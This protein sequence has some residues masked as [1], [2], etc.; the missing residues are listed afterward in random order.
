MDAT[1]ID[2]V[3]IISRA[4]AV[5][6][7]IWAKELNLTTGSNQVSYDTLNTE[8]IDGDSKHRR[9]CP[10]MVGALGGM[11]ADKIKLI[12]TEKGV[13]VNSQGTIT[14]SS[15]DLILTQ[16]GKII[17]GRGCFGCR[18]IFRHIPVTI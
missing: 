8:K 7:G 11:Y 5:N 6:A 1:N 4:T 18:V 13:G 10:L 2:R 9:Q 16:E 12:G 14:A 17:V 3:D 15:G